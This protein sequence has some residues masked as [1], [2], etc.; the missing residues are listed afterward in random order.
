MVAQLA[1]LSARQIVQSMCNSD[2][3]GWR[4]AIGESL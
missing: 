4:L 2:F 1:E 3:R